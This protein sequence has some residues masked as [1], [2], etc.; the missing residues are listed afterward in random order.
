MNDRQNEQRNRSGTGQAVDRA[1]NERP[2][3]L[4]KSRAAKPAIEFRR[5]NGFFGMTVASG[6][7][8]V[9]VAVDVI[10]VQMRVLMDALVITV[11]GDIFHRAKGC[12]QIERA[13]QDQHESDAKF[14]AHPKTL[15]ERRCQ[16]E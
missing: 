7:V 6:L 13:E 3:H 11:G 8:A 14:Q 9:G 16:T 12:S 2:Q 15:A 1:N 5:R 10:A 4:I